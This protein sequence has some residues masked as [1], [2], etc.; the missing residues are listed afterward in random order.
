[1]KFPG[2]ILGAVI[3][4]ALIGGPAAAVTR[5][6]ATIE[7]AL[8]V[9]RELQSMPDLQIP[10][11]LLARAEGI[12][13]LPANVKV[14][15]IFGARFGNG[16]LLVRNANRDWSNP[17][18]VTTGGGSWGFQVGGQ[19]ADIV[20]VLTTRRSIEGITDGKLTLGADASVSAGPV[21]RTAMAS[22]SLT[23]DS[24]VYAYS[25]SKGLF[26]GVSLEGNGVFIGRKANRRFYDGEDSA[27]AIIAQTTAPPPP[28]D[29]LVAAVRRMTS[30]TQRVPAENAEPAA[31]AVP[32]EKP[33]EAAR[34][35]PLPDPEP[36]AEP[37]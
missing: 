6:E 12:V 36:G 29:E 19:V 3:A 33:V 2:L 13:I 21:G 4:G 28:A 30:A 34:T 17:V 9:L 20:L 22:T 1:M 8:V 16:V 24:E 15:L 10:D 27:A 32:T 14:G 31:V 35:Y 37:R 25:R 26:A 23:F 5:E 7:N 18:F 11:Q